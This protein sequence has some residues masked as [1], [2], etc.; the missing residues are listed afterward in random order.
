MASHHEE[1]LQRQRAHDRVTSLE[2]FHALLDR[3][4]DA[5]TLALRPTPISAI[6][7]VTAARNGCLERCLEGAI[8]QQRRYARRER[9]TIVDDA[10]DQDVRRERRTTLAATARSSE[11]S[12]AYAGAEEKRR[13]I[14]ELGKLGI[15]PALAAFALL[16][17]T[18]CGFSAGANRNALLLHHAGDLI[19]QVDDDVVWQVA[20]PPGASDELCFAHGFNPCHFEYFEDRE[21]AHDAARFIECDVLARHEAMLG[22]SIAEC[23]ASCSG[24]AAG[25]GTQLTD[26]ML[27]LALGETGRV[28]VTQNGLVGDSAFRST[29]PFLLLKGRLRD[30]LH[31]SERTYRHATDSGVIAQTVAAPTVS[32]ST[33]CMSFAL[34]LDNRRLLPPFFPVQRNGDGIFGALLR[35]CC[36]HALFGHVPIELV[37]ERPERRPY[38]RESLWK[39]HR[40]ETYTIVLQMIGSLHL[41]PVTDPQKR[42]RMVGRHLCDMTASSRAEFLAYIRE[43]AWLGVQSQ[44]GAFQALFAEYGRQPAYW[45][46]DCDRYLAD[47]VASTMEPAFG[48]PVD[49]L[50]GRSPDDALAR[51]MDLVRRFGELLMLWPDVVD[52]AE[53]LRSKGV[54]LAQRL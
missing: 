46:D 21:Q 51:T 17:E 42:M 9:I 18:G 54:L 8:R 53:L 28:A 24:L 6:G 44:V 37:H 52:A 10:P 25:H 49:L 2:R 20:V 14:V 26:N 47:L 7:I 16:D 15:D 48:I 35:R 13:F 12:I 33:F 30:D 45:A 39:A 22:L 29:W 4:R 3:T 5:G 40:V 41:G 27:H 23:A 19:F 36:D 1:L 43:R 38:G 50:D 34:G 32:E 31:R 11:V